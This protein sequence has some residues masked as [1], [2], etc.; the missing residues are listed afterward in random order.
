MSTFSSP[1]TYDP[2]DPLVWLHPVNQKA[3]ADQV[4]QI[5]KQLSELEWTAYNPDTHDIFN[6]GPIGTRLEADALYK[7]WRDLINP[8]EI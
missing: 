3:I 7:Q 5:K 4:T 8:F 1:S 6:H 2:T